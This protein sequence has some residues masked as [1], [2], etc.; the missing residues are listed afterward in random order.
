MKQQHQTRISI[1]WLVASAI[2]LV[3]AGVY[4][5][6]TGNVRSGGGSVNEVYG[7]AS[8]AIPGANPVHSISSNVNVSEVSG[9]GSG[10]KQLGI[11]PTVATGKAGVNEVLGR[12]SGAPTFAAAKA[13][14][15]SQTAALHR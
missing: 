6:D 13:R 14:S 1:G 2:V 8:G 5:E 15:G 3:S 11:G 9:R 4:A 10:I 7:R 12:S